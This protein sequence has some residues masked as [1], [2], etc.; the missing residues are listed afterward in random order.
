MDP[1]VRTSFIPKKPA[2]QATN[3][4]VRSSGVGI[5]FFIALIIFLGSIVLA[6]G[7]FAYEKYLQ[8][9]L[10][11]KSA[12][13]ARARAAFE[14]ATINDLM[15]LDKRLKQANLILNTH[16]APSAI[17]AVIGNDT[18]SSVAFDKFSLTIGDDRKGTLELHGKTATFS[19]VALESDQF[20]KDKAL[21]DV[22]FSGF[23]VAKDGGVEFV[24]NATIDPTTINYRSNLA[25]VGQ[26]ADTTK[27][28]TPTTPTPTQTAATTTPPVKPKP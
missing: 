20:N 2:V 17:F 11:T 27:P 8:Q 26:S 4:A 25:L 21:K 1:L 18:L 22:L 12:S 9:S 13:L 15:R 3:G 23:T 16:T 28:A 14:P 5:F 19:E 10:V 7:A 24:V 6:G